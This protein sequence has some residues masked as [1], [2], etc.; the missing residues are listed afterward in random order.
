MKYIFLTILM[1]PI[2]AKAQCDSLKLSKYNYSIGFVSSPN[3]TFSLPRSSW[4]SKPDG[5]PVT[6]L[7][8]DAAMESSVTYEGI[9]PGL[10]VF[11]VFSPTTDRKWH[12]QFSLSLYLP[13]LVRGYSNGSYTERTT[14]DTLVSQETGEKLPVDSITHYQANEDFVT[15]YYLVGLGYHYSYA[16]R[17][18]MFSVGTEFQ[19]YLTYSP[20]VHSYKTITTYSSPA[21]FSPNVTSSEE[22]EWMTIRPHLFQ[23][24]LPVSGYVKIATFDGSHALFKKQRKKRLDKVTEKRKQ[25]NKVV[26]K[27]SASDIYLGITLAPMYTFGSYNGTNVSQFNIA[28]GFR[29]WMTL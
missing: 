14:I 20:Q 22:E 9:G 28:S 2:L 27:P 17:R 13:G 11:R 10:Q 3:F 16:H 25:R 19:Y 5:L 24:G 1:L 8:N 15:Q 6:N 7:P 29:L 18:S 23:F 26:K 21:M 12:H 4:S